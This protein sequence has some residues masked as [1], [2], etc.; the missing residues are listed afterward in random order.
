[1]K[2]PILEPADAPTPAAAPRTPDYAIYK[3]NSRG[4]G[5]VIR[6][7]LNRAK[8][9]VFVDAAAQSGEKQFDWERK[10]T[11]KWGLAD[12]GTVLAT[13]QGRLPQAKLFHQSEKANSAFELT[14]REDPERAPYLMSVSRQ[15]T[16]DKSLRK[17]TIPLTH[18][19]A[20]ILEAAL[21]AAV[22]RLL[23]W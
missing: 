3:P 23:R 8:A 17:V 18:G 5:G 11:M 16:A 9:A 20:A 19:E 2:A 7:S 22:N 10:I 4:T 13:L 15:E 6:F 14:T 1:M 12:M 21:R